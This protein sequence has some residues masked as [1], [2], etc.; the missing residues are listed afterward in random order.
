MSFYDVLFKK[1]ELCWYKSISWYLRSRVT[2]L[3]PVLFS[4]LHFTVDHAHVTVLSLAEIVVYFTHVSTVCGRLHIASS[5][6]QK[7]EKIIVWNRLYCTPGD[8]SPA[9]ASVSKQTT[10]ISHPSV[11]G[12]VVHISDLSVELCRS[13]ITR[14][15]EN[16]LETR[17]LSLSCSHA[18]AVTWLCRIMGYLFCKY[19]QWRRMCE[20]EGC[21]KIWCSGR[22]KLVKRQKIP[23]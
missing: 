12:V 2:R 21:Q 7:K 9:T 17:S 6:L 14:R 8:R 19:K 4:F 22:N 11:V 10:S 3:D 20:G 23:S 15:T 1:R 5:V 18:P 16:A 13:Q